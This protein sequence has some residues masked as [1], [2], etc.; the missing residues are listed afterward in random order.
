M[1]AGKCSPVA[2]STNQRRQPRPTLPDSIARRLLMRARLRKLLS[3][4]ASEQSDFLDNSRR[5]S[6]IAAERMRLLR[7]ARQYEAI[8]E[9]SEDAIISKDLTGRVTS[10][11]GSAE[12]IF[13][14]TAAEMLGRPMTILFPTERL[15][16]EGR[17]L[18]RICR[19]EKVEHFETV[20]Q[21]KD[22]REISVSVT[23][24]PITNERGEVVG[25]S[26]IARNI[27]ERVQLA[28]RIWS[29]AN[30]DELTRLPNRRLFT[31]RLAGELAR[32]SRSGKLIALMFID[33]DRF[34]AVNDSLGHDAGDQLLI[35]AA[36]R[37]GECVRAG[38]L[39]ARLGGDEFIVL[40]TDLESAVEIDP[41]ANRLISSIQ[42]PFAVRSEQAQISASIGIAV[43]PNDGQTA[44]TLLR[45]ADQAMYEAKKDGRNR[46]RYF[47]Q[48]LEA[49]AQYRQRVASDLQLALERRQFELRY[50]PIM[51]MRSGRMAKCEA[52]IRWRHPE[53]G[54][55]EQAQF[56]AVAEESGAMQA[57]SR[58]AI[59]GAMHQATQWQ[60]R[61]GPAF[62]IAIPVSPF[63][64]ESDERLDARWIQDMS[65]LGLAGRSLAIQVN[66][67]MLSE[68]SEA[69]AARLRALS[70]FG[71]QIAVDDFGAGVSCLTELQRSDVRYL[72]IS[73][74][75]IDHLG[76][77][78]RESAMCEA[79]VRMA[80]TLGMQAIA[81]GVETDAQR[82]FISSIG[83]D[84]A[85]GHLLARPLTPLAFEA[86][87]A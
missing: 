51:D 44:E 55:L 4:N 8:V 53:L 85:Q 12:R 38:D 45:H 59:R 35:E 37:I 34:K 21:T 57:I 73:R 41:I 72:R 84:Y 32:A 64:L 87:M 20:R 7:L 76:P 54:E 1:R 52:V 47:T 70:R 68:R 19:G 36:R 16:E 50:Q 58:W 5:R 46:T 31:E 6:R 43:F 9:S 22:G 28:Q 3:A 60:R 71:L 11:N 82:A 10:W 79:I 29:Q 14:Y 67:R 61:F 83:C 69:A 81:V 77:G 80:H 63:H 18:E 30:H 39:V 78:S 25:A 86:L 65:E 74:S 66:E 49:A 40:L 17:I 13:G 26:K 23:I 62:Q 56:L 15:D 48:S 24:S 27:T 42:D 2:R 75:L 33:L